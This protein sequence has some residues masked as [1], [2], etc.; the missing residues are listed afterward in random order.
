MQFLPLACWGFAAGKQRYFLPLVGVSL[1][2]D[3][4]KW[5]LW[6]TV[7]FCDRP[8]HRYFLHIYICRDG[9]VWLLRVKR[10]CPIS[11]V[12]FVPPAEGGGAFAKTQGRC[13]ELLP[14]ALR[15]TGK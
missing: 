14:F 6:D 10:V 5:G 11:S 4:V 3:S 13:S 1:D 7:I 12:I 2:G 8:A 15:F 9:Q